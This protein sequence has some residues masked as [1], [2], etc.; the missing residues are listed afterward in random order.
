[1]LTFKHAELPHPVT[2]SIPHLTLLI[3][4]DC[5]IIRSLKTFTKC[6]AEFAKFVANQ[7]VCRQRWL[8]AEGMCDEY[9]KRARELEQDN[10]A[11]KTKLKHARLDKNFT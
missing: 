7:E 3:D 1:M 8:E 11:L 4:L 10:E 2:Q 9:T 6:F 5:P